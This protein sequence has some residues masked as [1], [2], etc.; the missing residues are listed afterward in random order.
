MA[1][2]S[3]TVFIPDA[4]MDDYRRRGVFTEVVT[5]KKAY[6]KY[7][8]IRCSQYV[9]SRKQAYRMY[10][11]V[12]DLRVNRSPEVD[13]KL[14]REYGRLDRFLSD[15]LNVRAMGQLAW[16][17]GRRPAP[18]EWERAGFCVIDE[19]FYPLGIKPAEAQA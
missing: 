9:I 5:A 7:L 16:K 1:T 11:D 8:P 6:A 19:L 4:V 15:A 12:L 3:V 18:R 13:R 2:G 14:F 17:P 10:D